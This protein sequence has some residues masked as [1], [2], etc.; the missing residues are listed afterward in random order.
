LKRQIGALRADNES[1]GKH[2]QEQ[3]SALEKNLEELKQTLSL[4]SIK[5]ADLSAKYSNQS[6]KLADLEKVSVNYLL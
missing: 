4:D 2:S 5:Y 6:E 1:R 3:Y